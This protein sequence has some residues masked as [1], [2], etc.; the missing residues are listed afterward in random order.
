[1]RPIL[2]LLLVVAIL[3]LVQAYMKFQASLPATR[4]VQ[5]I[6][7]KAEGVYTADITLTFDAEPDAFSLEPTSLL[8]LFR[9]QELLRKKATVKAGTPLLI[10]D[11]PGMTEGRNEFYIKAT[12]PEDETEQSRAVRVRVLRDG[13]PV[14]E[15]TLWS[16]P[17]APVEGAIHVD[18]PRVVITEDDHDH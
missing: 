3:G 7:T 14:V 12:P 18:V 1:M 11:I 2:A 5:Q 13:I 16:E 4:S 15:R 6:E 17:G 9:G 8:V 10:T